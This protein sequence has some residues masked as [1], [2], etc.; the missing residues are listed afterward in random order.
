MKRGAGRGAP[1]GREEWNIQAESMQATDQGG[2]PLYQLRAKNI[3]V[4][5]ENKIHSDGVARSLGFGGALVSGVAVYS[6]MTRPLVERYGE[7]WLGRGTGLA[8]FYKPAYEGDLLD[9]QAAGPDSLEGGQFP[10]VTVRNA[11]GVELARLEGP[12]GDAPLQQEEL[13]GLA[14]TARPAGAERVPV[15]WEAV[16][17]RQPLW[18]LQW[19]PRAED[20]AAWC[21]GVM[22]DL[23]L[24]RESSEAPL[25]PGLVL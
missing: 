7:A 24:Y 21:E 22:D 12:P 4:Q 14:A 9:I 19:R 8:T 10:L 3:S 11:S 6:Y 16:R 1:A 5:S 20:N 23:P 17:L 18:T 15:S 13:A 25:H 2:W